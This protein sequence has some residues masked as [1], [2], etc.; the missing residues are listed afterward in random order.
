M[1]TRDPALLL[2]HCTER[3]IYC[4]LAAEDITKL[5]DPTSWSCYRLYVHP[6]VVLAVFSCYVVRWMVATRES[7]LLA[8]RLITACRERQG[9]GRGHRTIPA[10]RGSSMTSKPIALLLADLGNTKTHS[11]PHVANDNPYSEAQYFG[12]CAVHGT[13]PVSHTRWQVL[14]CS[15]IASVTSTGCSTVDV[16]PARGT[17]TSFEPPISA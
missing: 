15:R 13:Y 12:R 4:V 3:T 10:D 8:E 1:A 7:A 6:Y 14:R 11:R 5:T 16:C 9:I 17:R 2:H